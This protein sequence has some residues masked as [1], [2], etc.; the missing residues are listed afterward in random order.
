MTAGLLLFAHGARDP[1]WALPFD[2]VARRV[3]LAR[4][5]LPV[6]LAFLEFMSPDIASAAATLA[7]QGCTRVD[8]VPLFLG[9]GGHVRRDLPVLLARLGSE[10]PQVQ[11]VLRA[12]IGET[13]TV[14]QAMAAA[15]LDLS[16]GPLP[17][18]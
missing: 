10:Y 11:W 18:A 2:D 8:V 15:A 9:A 7:A 1:N 3:R 4:P 13:D 6:V 17:P 14:V 12:A 16:D 5:G